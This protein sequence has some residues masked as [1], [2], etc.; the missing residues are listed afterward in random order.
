MSEQISIQQE[1]AQVD[2][3]KAEESSLE[4]DKNEIS[5]ASVKAESTFVPGSG[6]KKEGGSNNSNFLKN[7]LPEKEA[8]GEGAAGEAAGAEG[9]GAGA[10]G[11][12]AISEFAVPALI[13]WL[14]G[15]GLFA[16]ADEKKKRDE[17]YKKQKW[18]IGRAHV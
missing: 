4:Q 12:G 16:L 18:K 5:G 14:G 3:L 15:T 1:Q 10:E 2:K 7:F 8:A 11:I 9:L 13:A 6:E 17:R